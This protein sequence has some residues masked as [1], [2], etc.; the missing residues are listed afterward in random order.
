LAGR[1]SGRFRAGDRLKRDMGKKILLAGIAA[2]AAGVIYA[3]VI[4]LP[5][6]STQPRPLQAPA[7][8]PDREPVHLYFSD[9]DNEYLVAEKRGM[10]RTNDPATDAITIV[11]ALVAGPDTNLMPTL[12][13]QTRLRALFLT[14]DH[15]A[16]V[17]FTGA[18]REHHPGGSRTE[19]LTVYSVVNSLVLNLPE[20]AS[21]KILIDGKEAESLAGHIDLRA[22]FRADMLL[23][24]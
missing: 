5:G 9:R 14:A 22:P 7:A 21:V 6:G 15:T 23:V 13:P 20:I 4:Y 24:R 8:A 10:I 17:D 12:P 11:E 1:G 2:L 3:A 18:I 19:L 16:V